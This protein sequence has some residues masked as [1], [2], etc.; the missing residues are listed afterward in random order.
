[1]TGRLSSTEP[2]IQNIPIRTDDGR[3]IRSAFV[4]STDNGILISADYSQIELRILAH[5]AGCKNML[6]AFNSGKDLHRSTAAS[7][8]NVDEAE[9]TKDMRRMAKAVNFGIVYGMSAWGLADELHIS[10]FEASEF[11]DKYFTIYPEIKTYLDDVVANTKKAGYTTTL[12]N[13]RRYMPEINSSNASLRQ[14]AE[15][16]AK[17]APIQGTAADIIKYAM[18]KVAKALKDKNLKSKLIA[19]VHD[20]LVIDTVS[21]EEEQIKTLLKETMESVVNLKVVLSAEVS[22]GYNWDMK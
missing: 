9:V 13:R 22:S 17:N 2:N 4:P 7:I 1:L 20:E 14:F 11:I 16:T 18:I 10:S 12:Y 6:A 5:L 3:L 8:Y 21:G 19:Q 15:R